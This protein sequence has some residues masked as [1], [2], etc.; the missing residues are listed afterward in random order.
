MMNYSQTDDIDLL[1]LLLEEEGIELA[2]DDVIISRRGL[3]QA[4]AS[5]QQRRLWFLYELEP[6]SSAY[7]ICS[8]F[9]VQGI[10]NVP[11]LQQAFQQLQQR[12]ESLRSTF[13][14]I[15]GEPWQ[16]IH[17][18][19]LTELVLEDWSGNTN[20]ENTT[21]IA[22]II[23]KIARSEGDYTFNL[24][25]GS[26]LRARLFKLAP[27]QHILT[28]TLHHIIADAWSMGVILQEIAIFY[29]LAITEEKIALPELTFQ[30]SDYALWQKEKFSNSHLENS[31]NYWQKQLAELPTLQFPLDFSR[32]KLQTF[33]GDLVKFELS[34][35][36]TTAIRTFSQKEGAT[37]FMTLM[38][39][40]QALLARYTGQEDIPVGT[41]IANRPGMDAEKLIGFFVNM[42]VVRTNLADEP[43]F[44][45]LLN[46][47]K[48][49]VLSAF[50]H[51]E[52]PFETL[53]E[54][55]NLERD[56][57]RNPLF[58]IAFTLLN[59]P[60]PEFSTDDL[61]VSILATQEAARFDLELFITE[62]KDNLHGVFSYNVDLLKRETVERF[63]RHFC[64]LL[65]NLITQPDT[66]VSRIPFLLTEELAFLA[67]SQPAQSFPVQFCLHEI[68]T[69]QAKL[70]PQQTALIFEQEKL[71]YSEVNHRANQ[72]A[73]YLINTGVKPEARVGLWLSR[74]LD[75]VI[76]ILGILKAGGV[77]VLFDPDYPS[78][79]IAYMLEDSQ[80]TILLT[81]T[82]FQTQIPPHTAKTIFIDNCQT[83]I[84]QAPTTEPEILVL[85]DNAAYIIYTSGSTGKPKGVVV[86]HRHVVRLMLATEKWFKFNAKD[87]WTLFH[88]CAFDFS[89]WEIWG[90]LFYGGRLVI[91]P[92]LVSR[93]PEEF[94]NLLCEEKVTVLNQTPSAFRQLIQAESILCREGELELRYVIFGG[95]A[96]D[97]A[98]LEPW[99]ERHDDQFPLLV[100]MY[101]ITETTVHVTYRPLSL[102][103]VKKRLGSL[104]GKP[105]P[106]LSL[107]ILDRHFQ[108]VPIGVV[109]EMYIGGAGVTRGYFHRPQLTAER[110]IPNPFNNKNPE[111]LYKTGDLARFLD[112]GDI[113][114]IGRNDHQVKVRGFRIELG[115][116]AAVIKRH[117]EV[118]DALV[119]VR[120]ENKE[121]IRIEAYI[122]PKKQ[123]SDTAN[124]T[125]EQTQEW[126]YTFNDTYNIT[127]FET[128]ETN[129]DFNIIGWNSS[130]DNQPIPAEEMRQWLNNT[131]TRIQALKPQIVLEIGCGTGMI[132][133]NIAPQ[134]ESYWGTDFS[135][136]AITRLTNI[137]QNRS[138]NNVNLL[139]R[140]AIDFS[141]IPVNY[142]DTIV[143]NS[144]AQYFPSIEYLQQVITNAL[145]ILAPGGS[146][147]IGDNRNLSLLNYFHASVAYFQ[148]D[149]NTDQET[150]KT[151][152]RRIAKTENELVI[153]PQFF[154]N[155]TQTFSN[156]TAVEIQLK[157]EN[158]HNELTKYRYDVV[159]HKLGASANQ[160][161]EIIWQDWE[162]ANL[163]LTDLKQQIIK[164][165][166]I[167]WRNIPNARLIKDA[168]IY[169]WMS[170]NNSENTIGELRQLI[171]QIHNQTAIE[172]A[173]LYTLAQEIGYDITISY[174]P[175]KSDYFDVCFYRPTE[176]KR[177]APLMPI[178]SKLSTENNNSY[179]LD[180]LKSRFSKSLI[181]QL[182][183]QVREKLPEYM[184]PSAFVMLESFPLTPSGKLD[185]RALPTPERDVTISKQAF[186]P[187]TTPTEKKLFQLWIDVLGI[188]Q[189]SVTE[190]FFHLGGHSLLATKLVS[191]IREEFNI[192]LPLRAVFE[193]STISGLG[194]E[195]D[196]LGA[197]NNCKTTQQ[198][199]IAVIPN[200]ENLPLSF[201][202]SRLWFLDLLEP[203]NAAY[204][205]SVAFRLE[206]NLN[207][208]ALHQSLQTI[209]QRHEVLRTTFENI[210]GAP[211][212]IIHEF[213][214]VPLTV[215]NLSHLDSQTQQETL[216]TAIQE[217]IITPFNLRQ[218]P[219]L[220]VHLYQLSEDVNVLVLVIHHIIADGWSLG[221]MIKELSLFYT[222]ICQ[223]NIK[224]LPPLSIQY[225]DFANWQQTV[226]AQTQLPAQLAYWKQKLAGAN[227]VLQLPTDYPR[228][229]VASYQG[230]AVSFTINKQISGEFQ[231]LCESQGATLFMGLLGV[232]SILLMRYSGQEDFL[233]GTPIA[234]R[235]RKQVEDLIGF[236]VNTL[237]IRNDVSGNPDFIILLSRIKEETLQAYAHQDVP[238][239]RI[240]EEIHPERNLSHHPLFQVMFVL[241]NAPMG[242]LELP[243]LQ[244]T[245]WELEQAVAKF[246]LTLLM[247]ETEQGIEGIWEYRTDL[248]AVE[249]IDRMIGHFQTLLDHIIAQ[250]QKPI[251]ELSI[252]TTSEHHQLLV[253]WNQTQ[254][255]YPQAKQNQCLH[256]LF[257]L[258]VE[259]TPD[260]VAV[261]F[262]NQSLTY[263]QLNQRANQLAHYLQSLGVKP[264]VLVGI[265]IERSLEMVIGLLGILKAGGAYVPL[266]PNYPQER[267][268]FM[269]EDAQISMLLTQKQLRESLDIPSVSN[270]ICLDSDWEIIAQQNTENLVSNLVGENLAYLIY[271]S[272]STG[273]PKGVMITHR[274][275][276]NHM[277][278]MQETFSFQATDKVLQKTPFS[279]DASVW[280][281]YAPLLTGGQLIVAEKGGHQD[282]AYLLKLISEQQV[283]VLQL[284]PSLLQMLLEQRGIENCKSLKH[285]FCGGEAL[286]VELKQSL[287][288][289]LNVNL[290]NLYGPTETCIDATF[291]NC[292]NKHNQQSN[293]QIV[294]IGSP[295][296]N[297]QTYI[298][299]SHLQRVPIGIPGELYIGGMGLARGY[300]QRPE[301]T[302]EKF[303]PHPFSNEP[304]ARLYKTGDLVRYLP[305]GNIE[306]LGRI[307]HQVKIR[308][309]RI[310]LGEIEAVLSQHPDILNAVVVTTIDS[311]GSKSL[312]AY[313]VTQKQ[314]LIASGALRDFLTAK[315]PDYMI[316][317]SFVILDHLPLTPNGKLDRKALSALNVNRNIDVAQHI[318]PRTPLEYQLVEIW[319]EMLKVNPIGV[320]ENFFDLGGHS[321]L[322]IRL[323]AAIEQKLNF[324]LPVVS[325]FR[326]GTIEKI[327]ALLEQEKPSSYLDVLVP[328]QTQGDLPPLF[329]IHQAGG[330][331]LSYSVLAEKLATQMEKKR[332]IYA[333]QARGLDD[334][335]P[336]LD[337]IEAMA[338][339]YINAIR[340]IQPCRPYLLGGHSLGGL[341]AFAMAHQLE[342]VG[343]Q[344]EH[345]LIIDTH[346]PL[347]TDE[348]T[349]SL[350]DNVGIL[351]FI[352][353]Q[354]G[355]HFNKTVSINYQELAS[356]DQNS[357][358]EYVLQTLQDHEV[359]PPDSG[360]N[361]IA[362]LI[363]VYKA[364]I[365]ASLVYQPQPIKA[366][367]ILFKTPSLAA[368]FPDDPTLGWG[369][370][371]SEQ[372]QVCCV[373]GEHQTMLKEPDVENLVM[374][375]MATLT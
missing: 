241:Q 142:F 314:Q 176:G 258:Q 114:Y 4:P 53:V 296:A 63:A 72:L 144:V 143:I 55:L 339:S 99:F 64:Q 125:K 199:I 80:V 139:T 134:V 370:L 247:T 366:P 181:S 224:S 324:N 100:N 254:V 302:A 88:S 2:T 31:L 312:I 170:E 187:A 362:G 90:A 356:L 107:Y 28:L 104:I 198:D 203:N 191:R 168:A 353:E 154:V 77:Y 49:T 215:T 145:Q 161:I 24:Q 234:N 270:I 216:K 229:A 277:L 189:I 8:V 56:T 240:V 309:F 264:D 342:T 348:I 193:H 38:A 243:N 300:F 253:E 67:P 18:D 132:L 236:F 167:G 289:K 335:Q 326:E 280:E 13:V 291:W 212:Q 65:E 311:S 306:F 230:S 355:L 245:P 361:L 267:L 7:N 50:E 350:E 371:T 22:E 298:L 372:V 251:H 92:Y 171:N 196:H 59:A 169:Q 182:K 209:I 244:L 66:P 288:S 299:D 111:R 113:E 36:L 101:G 292:K 269:L 317:S 239:E 197:L 152:V 368:Q 304:G 233:I 98:S 11:A 117:P 369:Q 282:S 158:S 172:P 301:L 44:Y 320:T 217:V 133:L 84:T 188:D 208:E 329:L 325:L 16:K 35:N 237:V 344:I 135:Q 310:E 162:T 286:S 119:I 319:E 115:E 322:A 76:A 220:R 61:E 128:V 87:V 23:A 14:D 287:L 206:G 121:D 345:L 349:A 75:L 175:E 30:Y 232:F 96:L 337:T 352:V 10:L 83:E 45:T 259:K 73:H 69:Q 112:N 272:G 19:V 266:D 166:A 17:T 360:R 252:L 39:A 173:D 180:P 359:I 323:I 131:L 60:K 126:Q 110:M 316:P 147:F 78:D 129:E 195:I 97:L 343:E 186:V 102:K 68:F 15:D 46:R 109:G 260:A 21:E 34:K 365:Q 281:F 228:P 308:G 82:Q 262:E 256:Q 307:D 3:T 116:I 33:R 103:D 32:P 178:S 255:E 177:I 159:L 27:E 268:T 222:A 79:R 261:V 210:D 231:K 204:N 250:P 333:I 218:L 70:R 285:I 297:T 364:N 137:I 146:L 219:L 179:W 373:T 211:I 71:T 54:R 43:N 336:P 124:L 331:G 201:S 276:C 89:V 202:Q 330:Y 249:T 263:R 136:A 242:K 9:S 149:D 130:Y 164:T 184:C 354:I 318:S 238:F 328:L 214:E 141:E 246:D 374:E 275:I 284:V 156:L 283:T 123:S 81:H 138:L 157:A 293:Q 29:K 85:P 290:H 190:D 200:R 347:A 334:K 363:S 221:L 105:I 248:F 213:S 303:I 150:L 165:G 91:V 41:S 332:P 341:I 227:E 120:E 340:E 207:L 93:S 140:E 62:S 321:L 313:L 40:F 95:E 48:N 257:E 26:L 279:F 47:V 226:F 57:S 194:T 20:T 305:D 42:L 346:P 122:I 155:L 118:R 357:Q 163:L 6:T 265:C 148:A 160:P 295:I 273:K 351:C 192:A 1:E 153:D 367:I 205:I 127:Q 274:A 278:W 294:P 52:V 86:T 327:A 106:D 185:R 58:Q 25:T 375:I 37:L 223:S 12:H 151:Q 315:L 225:A 108:P 235:N 183:E 74:S 94:Y 338:N 271:T 5:F 51:T 358:F 174:S